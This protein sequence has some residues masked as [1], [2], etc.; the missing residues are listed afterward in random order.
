MDGN[1]EDKAG[2]DAR[3]ASGNVS[4]SVHTYARLW[5]M[6]MQTKDFIFFDSPFPNENWKLRK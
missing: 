1:L 6:L 4:V 5:V 3:S 2:M